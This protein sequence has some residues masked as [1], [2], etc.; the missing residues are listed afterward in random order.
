[1]EIYSFYKSSTKR[2]K[3]IAESALKGNT[4]KNLFESDFNL[5]IVE[6]LNG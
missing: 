6:I 2:L 3:P 1:M 4:L 5:N